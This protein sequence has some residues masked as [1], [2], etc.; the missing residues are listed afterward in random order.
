MDDYELDRI[1]SDNPA[2]SVP[3]TNRVPISRQR[4][5]GQTKVSRNEAGSQET[6]TY[7]DD[8]KYNVGAIKRLHKNKR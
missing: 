3:G 1:A 6:V 5:N 2:L 8:S 4:S 7:A